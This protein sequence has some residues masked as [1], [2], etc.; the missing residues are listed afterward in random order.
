[1]LRGGPVQGRA[2]KLG[3]HPRRGGCIARPD[4]DDDRIGTGRCDG[5][6]IRAEPAM[7]VGIVGARF[8]RRDCGRSLGQRRATR[9]VGMG[10]ASMHQLAVLGALRMLDQEH[11][12]AAR[13]LQKQGQNSQQRTRVPDHCGCSDALVDTRHLQRPSMSETAR[14]STA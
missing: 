3:E 14:R 6:P 4:L 10:L 9:D 12:T 11:V 13:A 5:A 7:L 8:V 1:M 2:R